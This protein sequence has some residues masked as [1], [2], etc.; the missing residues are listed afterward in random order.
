MASELSHQELQDV[1]N[2]KA[3]SWPTVGQARSMATELISL[4]AKCARLE[5]ALST[6]LEL[7][8]VQVSSQLYHAV[9]ACRIALQ[10]R[11]K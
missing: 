4:R 10:D 11:P 2:G 9:M 8:G 7:K 1:L 6:V 5:A 3:L